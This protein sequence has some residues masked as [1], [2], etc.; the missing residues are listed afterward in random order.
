VLN[1]VKKQ[2]ISKFEK[3][4]FYQRQKWVLIADESIQFGNKKLLLA[5]TVPEARCEQG[6]ELSYKDLTPLVLKVGE[7]WKAERIAAEIKQQIDLEQISYCIS[8]TGSNLV[9]TFK[10]L[11]CTHIPDINH[12]FSLIIKSVYEKNS[13][14]N[15][16][17]KTLSSIRARKSMS[18]IARIV[19]PN[20][21]IFNRFMNLTPLFEWGMKMIDLLDKKVLTEE[22]QTVLSFLES[23][24]L[25]DFIRD[26]Y[27]I[28]S[29]LNQIQGIL[30]SNGYNEETRKV[31]ESIFSKLDGDNALK[32][33]KQI[34]SY[35]EDLTSKSGGKTLCCSSD[36]IE[37]CFGKFKEIVKGN[38][39][40][41][42]TD[43]SLCIAVMTG[44]NT[45]ES[46]MEAMES[47]TMKK[48]KEWKTKNT[49][50]TLLP[51]WIIR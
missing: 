2:G 26:T 45:P 39:T 28:L 18:K 15:D 12:K 32:I 34:N 16:Y 43:L 24:P 6:K 48:V 25:R 1:W 20:Q 9:N 51:Y 5:L 42:I 17:T 3:R 21:R 22:E 13:L 29:S 23:A 14:L 40:V 41:G 11:N 19:P 36:I 4:E 37:S 33:R 44:I 30:K 49:A 35:F 7:S 46:T 47:I 8:D 27:R 10:T 31:A 38:K 50:Q